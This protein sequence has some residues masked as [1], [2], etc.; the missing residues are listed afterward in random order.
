MDAQIVKWGNG[1]GVRIPK[2]FMK[3]LGLAVGDL[4]ELKI[5]NNSIVLKKSF[6][7]RTLE[8]RAQKY[9]GELGPYDEFDWGNAEGREIW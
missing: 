5:E 3:E 1:Q 9:G 4:L 7:H 8:E 2:S 6:Q